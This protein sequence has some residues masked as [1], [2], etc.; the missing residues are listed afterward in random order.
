MYIECMTDRERH[1]ER[2]FRQHYSA[3]H[4][5]A[6][7]LLHDDDD[8]KDVVHDIF[9]KLLVEQT[10]LRE[11]TVL[12]YLLSCVRNQ[13]LNMMRNRNLHDQLQQYLIP[14]TEVEQTSPEELEREIELLASGIDA[15]VPPVCRE[16]IR[17]HFHEG[18]PLTEVARRLGV[19]HTTI[20]KHLHS[21][22]S[23]LRQTLVGTSIN[24]HNVYD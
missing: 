15:L 24:Y 3:M 20:Y 10:E 7:M 1:I 11:A 19:S 17:L 2:L 5:L 16:V 4:R 23:Q 22:L 8:S 6:Y 9:A 12:P 18:V 14:D 21:A 13:C